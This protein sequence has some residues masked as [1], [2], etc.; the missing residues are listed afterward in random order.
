MERSMS[1]RLTNMC[2]VVLYNRVQVCQVCIGLLAN[3][4]PLYESSS[5]GSSAQATLLQRRLVMQMRPGMMGMSVED[6]FEL[7]ALK[8]EICFKRECRQCSSKSFA[9]HTVPFQ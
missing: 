8:V 1:F 9:S 7:F 5:A 3:L 6:T 2:F 4:A